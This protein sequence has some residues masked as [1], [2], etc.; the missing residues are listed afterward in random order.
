MFLFKK[1]ISGLIAPL[2]LAIVIMGLGLFM[3]WRARRRGLG[4]V[5]STAGL[6]FLLLFGYGLPG[7]VMV[8]SLED[9]YP[10]PQSF[11]GHSGV[12][13]IVVLGG[14]MTSDPR[15]PVGS[16]LTVSSAL[17]V[18][19]AVRI[20]RHCPEATILLSGGPVFN[21][22][23]EAEG[24]AELI[25]SLGVDRGHLALETLS[26]DTEEQARFIKSMVGGDSLW[27]VTSAVH[28]P[29]SMALFSRAGLCCLAA[30]T[31]YLYKKRPRFHPS[32]L[33]PDHGGFKL[34]EAGW[35]EWLGFTYSKARGRI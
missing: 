4:L 35:H 21:P 26:R 7:N 1:I 29:R 10:A 24:M 5:T 6:V 11:S 23:P 33:F 9:R 15:L 25:V 28:M 22:V 16:Q 27:L 34:A 32:D 19:E 17:R 2:P 30:P 3:A 18:M 12:R 14:G 8:R 13:W 31:D 20:H